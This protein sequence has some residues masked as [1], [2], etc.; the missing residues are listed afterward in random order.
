LAFALALAAALV[1]A[2][3]HPKEHPEEHPEG[4]AAAVSKENL[5]AAIRGYVEKDSKLKGGYFCVFDTVAKAPLALTLVKVHDDKLAQVG[6]DTYF[7]CADFKAL[8][9]AVYDLD[10]FMRGESA[11]DLEVTEITIHKKDGKERY[12]WKEEGGVWTKVP[13]K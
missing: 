11:D 12:G 6:E 5:A 1:V 4:E 3:E 9:G 13:V 7:A 10:I 8:D 2:Q